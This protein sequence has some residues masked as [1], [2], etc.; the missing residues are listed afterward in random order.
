MA[1]KKQSPRIS[2]KEERHYTRVGK[3]YIGIGGVSAFINSSIHRFSMKNPHWEYLPAYDQK[4]DVFMLKSVSETHYDEKGRP[5]HA[6]EENENGIVERTWIYVELADG[7]SVKIMSDSNRNVDVTYGE[8]CW[9]CKN[10]QFSSTNTSVK[11][12]PKQKEFLDYEDSIIF[13]GLLTDEQEA[14]HERRQN[15]AY[16]TIV[17]D[18][19]KYG[20][21]L[22]KEDWFC[23]VRESFTDYSYFYDL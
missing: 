17:T 2:V 19:D 7:T 12:T 10:G 13:R 3:Q 21:P 4:G 9:F 5:I 16:R 18:K 22:H 20:N 1:K 6:F 23:D 15:E 8:K 11:L 14:E